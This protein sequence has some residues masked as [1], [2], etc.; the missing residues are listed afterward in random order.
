MM[1]ARAFLTS[2]MQAVTRQHA[3]DDW[4]LDDVVSYTEVSDYVALEQ[5][6]VAPKEGIYLHG[7]LLDSARWEGKSSGALAESEPKVLYAPLPVIYFTAVSH[8]IKNESYSNQYECAVYRYQNRHPRGFITTIS[9]TTT[10][11]PAHWTLR[12]VAA[13]C[14]L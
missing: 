12:S 10:Q 11:P 3:D 6:K 9:L 4:S 8:K 7:L 5:I 2:V 14:S 1:N 13:F